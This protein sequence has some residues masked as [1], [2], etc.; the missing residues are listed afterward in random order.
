[1]FY[2]AKNEMTNSRDWDMSI[3]NK[4]KVWVAW[5][6]DEPFPIT[7]ACTYAGKYNMWQYSSKASIPGIAGAVDM[8]VSYFNY[9]GITP[10]KKAGV[11]NVS[12]Q[13]VSAK[14]VDV[15]E[16]VTPTTTINLRTVD[17]TASNESIVVQIKKGD[18]V[19]RTA[20]G[21]NGWSKVLI[22]G[23]TLYAY[24]SYLQKIA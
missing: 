8:N 13:P 3:L 17:S 21:D 19:Y 6:P 16:V 20:V 9:D 2:A 15:C 18:M 4:Y 11:T 1:M 10:A 7:P 14:Y 24:S 12:I 5:Y 23:Q 22:N